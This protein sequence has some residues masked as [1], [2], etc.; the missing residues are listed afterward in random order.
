MAEKTQQKAQWTI[1]QLLEWTTEHFSQAGVEQA[2]LCAE[3]LLAEVLGCQRIDLYIR[4]DHCPDEEQRGRLR[5][6]VKRCA[7]HEPV[8]Y[9]LGKAHFY[10][11]ELKVSPAVLIPRSETEVLVTQAIDYCRHETNRPTVAVLDLCTG[12]GC[13]AIALA[14]HVV[15]TEIVALDRS[16]A[17][18]EIARHNIENHALAARITLVRSDLFDNINQANKVVFDLIVANPPYISAAEYENLPANV[19]DYEPPEALLGGADGLEVHKR[20]IDRAHPYLADGGAL[21]LET[22]YNQAEQIVALC[23]ASGYLKEI[24]AVRDSLGHK[25]VVKALKK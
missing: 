8:A 17:A 21:M 15:E 1:K 6:Y 4:F 2:R 5:E 12:S 23:A 18:L 9:V 19:R 14:A 25:R 7:A 10:S 3:L 11:L 20:I 22:A 13:I 24:T 16:A